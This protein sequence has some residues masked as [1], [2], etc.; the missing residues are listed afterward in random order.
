MP[1]EY[2]NTKSKRPTLWTAIAVVVSA[3]FESGLVVAAI[4]LLF[5]NIPKFYSLVRSGRETTGTVTMK[6]RENHMAIRIAYEVEGQKL[7][8]VGSAG[9]IGRTFESIEIGEK[10]PV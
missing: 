10:V 2:Q 6:E 3:V 9:N 5:L 7:F 4:G 8:T 1:D